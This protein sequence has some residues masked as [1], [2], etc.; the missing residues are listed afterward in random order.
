MQQQVSD[1]YLNKVITLVSS[2]E[3]SK[4]KTQNLADKVAK[5]LT[6]ISITVGVIAHFWFNKENDLAFALKEW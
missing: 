1:S 4:S 6:I 2:A 3:A 5:W